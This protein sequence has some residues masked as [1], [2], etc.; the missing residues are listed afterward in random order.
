MSVHWAL[1]DYHERARS[2]GPVVE[3]TF[4]AI[5]TN[6]AM[7]IRQRCSITWSACRGTSTCTAVWKMKAACRFP[8]R[9][10]ANEPVLGRAFNVIIDAFLADGAGE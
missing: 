8:T 5:W 2:N 1:V 3:R 6:M 10:F 9:C 7:W 4:P